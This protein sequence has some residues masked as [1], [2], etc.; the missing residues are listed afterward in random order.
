MDVSE[1]DDDLSVPAH[2]GTETVPSTDRLKDMK[3]KSAILLRAEQMAIDPKAPKAIKA[4]A[5]KDLRQD[6]QLR[7]NKNTD[8]LVS[9]TPY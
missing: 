6:A 8:A 5:C 7:S 2:V 3:K 9:T 1:D 4:L